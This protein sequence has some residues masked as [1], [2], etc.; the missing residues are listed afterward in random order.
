M[1]RARFFRIGFRDPERVSAGSRF[2]S[3]NFPPPGTLSFPM[4]MIRS[5]S[6]GCSPGPAGTSASRK[7]S[8][9][10]PA[11]N[12]IERRAERRRGMLAGG[13]VSGVEIALRDASTRSR[14]MN[15]PRNGSRLATSGRFCRGRDSPSF[16]AADAAID[17]DSAEFLA[18]RADQLRF[19]IAGDAFGFVVADAEADR[20]ARG[21]AFDGDADAARCRPAPIRRMFRRTQSLGQF[22]EIA[23][24]VRRAAGE[25]EVVFGLADRD[26]AELRHARIRDRRRCGSGLRAGGEARARIRCAQLIGPVRGYSAL[27]CGM[28]VSA[29]KSSR[30][31]PISPRARLRLPGNGVFI[32]L[33]NDAGDFDVRAERHARENVDGFDAVGNCGLYARAVGGIHARISSSY[34]AACAGSN[35]SASASTMMRKNSPGCSSPKRAHGLGRQPFAAPDCRQRLATR[36]TCRQSVPASE[37]CGR[38]RA[39]CP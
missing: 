28:R 2:F 13:I 25:V 36:N 23:G 37:E 4:S 22:G 7:R 8:D 20:R 15:L 6:H 30:R 27:R 29:A 10:A 11:K 16:F 34:A 31:L 35:E 21:I 5:S 38:A 39:P 9:G 3:L 12:V 33:E 24:R 18:Q 14:R 32:A 19:E 1:L 26:Q 17:P